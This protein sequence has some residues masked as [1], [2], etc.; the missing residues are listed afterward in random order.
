M[1]SL[2]ICKECGKEFQNDKGLHAH[3]KS[4]KLSTMEYYLKFF[5]RKDPVTGE[6]IR[7]IDKDQYFS[8]DFNSRK[9]FNIWINQSEFESVKKYLQTRLER[10]YSKREPRFEISSCELESLGEVDILTY[11]KYLGGYYEYVRKFVKNNR[12]DNR[13]QFGLEAKNDVK[14]IID[15]REQNP[16]NIKNSKSGTLKFGDYCLEEES[17]SGRLRIER[18]SAF[19]FIQ[20]MI[21]GFSRFQKEIKLAEKKGYYLVV[22]V[23][24]PIKKLLRPEYHKFSKANPQYYFHN[25][26]KLCQE[27]EN[28]QFVFCSGRSD[29]QDKCRIILEQ[30]RELQKTDIHYNF[31]KY[32]ILPTEL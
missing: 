25:M 22:L 24:A 26:R 19:D 28:L 29:A 10:L 30:G 6:L 2:V 20:T 7:F 18:K 17:Y 9:N 3:L 21:S 1:D 5:P 32:D 15:N 4:H 8:S 14:V 13:Y 12:F 23:E 16:F 31:K 11:D 27:N